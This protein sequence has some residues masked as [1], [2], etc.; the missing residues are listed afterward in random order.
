MLKVPREIGPDNSAAIVRHC[1]G[2]PVVQ[3]FMAIVSQGL[4]VELGQR[5]DD[6]R[7]AADRI[8]DAV[9][10]QIERKV[11]VSGTRLPSIR[12]MAAA[13]GT[14]RHA[15]V[16][17]YDRLTAQ[18]YLDARPGAGFY[19]AEGHR[20]LAPEPEDTR[21]YDVAWL[22]RE[23][24]ET[25]DDWLKV[26]GPWLPD[27]WMDVEAMQQVVRSLGRGDITHLTRYGPPLG[28]LPLRRELQGMMARLGVELGLE[29]ILTTG[30]TSQGFDLILRSLIKPGDAVLVEDPGYYN[31]FGYLRFHGARLIGVPRRVD[32]PDVDALCRLATEHGARIFF[33]Q[34]A[35]QNPTGSDTSPAVAH[36][37]L[38]AAKELDL[39][40]VEDD[41]YCDLDP[42]Q[43][44]RLATLDQ[45]DRVLYVRSFSKAL[46]GSLRVGFVAASRELIDN[47]ANIKVLSSISTSLFG[48][49][50]VCRLLTDGH[51]GRYLRRMHERIVEAR[52][53]ALRLLRDAGM[54]IFLEPRGGNF[55][56][57][58]F[59]GI[60]D[61]KQLS[62]RAR[63]Q[64]V[65]LGV[66]EVFRPNLERS[67]WMRF[68]VAL[69]DDPR[70]GRFL[71]QIRGEDEE[72]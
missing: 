45:L 32:G 50:L 33:T 1:T 14:S 61:A 21:N 68:N 4:I 49:K 13:C 59:P 51:Y 63:R 19:V 35:L 53:S 42:I 12:A 69:C 48:E 64:G 3:S 27:D 10:R 6:T 67:P 31:L 8:C 43:G 56:W 30:G 72:D 18:G 58:R 38:Q 15:V 60:D 5:P 66:G 41:T 52:N 2:Q 70:L 57:A 29:Q 24:L 62:E 23:V 39:I 55:L 65:I 46:S 22:I 34:S 16:D 17:A 20:R 37:L 54:E 11:L 47:L 7:P 40:L 26:G 25:S 71:N 36:R 9:L 44:V 28:Y